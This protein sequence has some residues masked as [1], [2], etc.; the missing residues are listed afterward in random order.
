[1]ILKYKNLAS[2]AATTSWS[3]VINFGSKCRE[4]H[5]YFSSS[6]KDPN[7]WLHQ[8]FASNI[9]ILHFR[10]FIQFPESFCTS[11]SIKCLKLCEAQFPDGDSNGKLTLN[12]SVLETLFLTKCNVWHLKILNISAPLL[13]TLGFCFQCPFGSPNVKICCPNL[14]SLEWLFYIGDEYPFENLSA[15]V[16][17]DC[18]GRIRDYEDCWT[19][20]RCKRP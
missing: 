3:R 5:L 18:S 1:M 16:T 20:N 2:N 11:S 9:K 13:K 15:L 8:L 12:F 7:E 19:T 6:S 10:D 17:A 4:L 14:A